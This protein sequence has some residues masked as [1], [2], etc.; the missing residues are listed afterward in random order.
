M[1]RIAA[2]I[3]TL[4]IGTGAFAQTIP[5]FNKYEQSF[6]DF[7]HGISGALPLYSSIGNNWS[8]GYGGQFPHLGF[9]LT[10]GAA[11]IPGTVVNNL[12]TQLGL[13]DVKTLFPS[14]AADL[15]DKYGVPLPGY[16][17]EVRIGGF[18]IP[19]DIGLKFGYIGDKMQG[20][21]LPANMKLDYLLTGFDVK[22][23]IVKEGFLMP[24]I[25]V[26][27]G[28]NY[29]RG[30]VQFP[31]TSSDITVLNGVAAPDGNTYWVKFTAPDMR[32]QWDS[33]VIDAKIQVS[34][35]LLI[36]TPYAGV[37]ASYGF[38][39]AGGGLTS[40]L[41]V[42]TTSSTGPFSTPTPAQINALNQAL[43]SSGQNGS[44]TVDGNGVFVQA[45]ANGLGF[46]AFGGVSIDLL[47][48]HLDANLMYDFISKGYGG[49]IGL[50]VQW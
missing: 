35:H 2:V 36:F 34:K 28:F 9:G 5:D 19:F 8:S 26:G 3:F 49:S 38:S 1:K 27:G 18:I 43:S 6:V 22:F 17:A 39:G 13:G 48:V 46:R 45:G 30:Y 11:T 33:K 7:A 15:I 4:A 37:G 20:L 14:Q 47:I 25:A 44:F 24:Q 31:T 10:V 23:P 32:F 50:R 42:S 41:Q 16:V 21:P 12:T 40:Q 29:V